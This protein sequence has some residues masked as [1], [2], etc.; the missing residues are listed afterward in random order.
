MQVEEQKVGGCGC[1]RSP[2]GYCIGWHS[3]TEDEYKEAMERRERRLVERAAK[4]SYEHPDSEG[5]E[6]D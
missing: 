6:T 5:G 3:L 2:T 1:G 4:S